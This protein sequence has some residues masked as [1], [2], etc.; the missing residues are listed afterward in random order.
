M[1]CA[2]S[3]L[4]VR[5]GA[6]VRDVWWSRSSR[7]AEGAPLEQAG[8]GLTRSVRAPAGV[9]RELLVSRKG[10]YSCPVA[11][12]V[13][14]TAN[15]DARSFR[16]ASPDAAAHSLLAT[17][18]A[19]APQPQRRPPPCEAAR[20]RSDAGRAAARGRP[21]SRRPVQP[22]ACALVPPSA[23]RAQSG[24]QSSRVMYSAARGTRVE[25]RTVRTALV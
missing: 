22:R 24:A 14:F 23:L 2:P 9:I 1:S 25:E 15:V 17:L 8:S 13:I 19:R 5:S 20:A 7:A 6:Q 3:A 10:A 18:Q 11:A 4:R 21:S 16:S 12:G